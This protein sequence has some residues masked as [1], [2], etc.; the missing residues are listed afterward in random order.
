MGTLY[1]GDNLDILRRYL[2]DESVDLVYLDPPFNSAQTYNAFFHEKDGTEAASQIK[3]FEDTWHWDIQ[4]MA[5]YKQITEQPGKVSDVMQAFYTFLG[6][7]DMMAYLTMMAPRLVELRRVL[8][9]TG[10]LYLHCDPTASHYLKLLCD[11]VFG[12]L[13]YRNEISWRRSQP[14]SHATV[15]FPNCRDVILRYSKGPE[16]IFNKVFGQHDP[17]YIQ[18]FYR[19]ADPNGRKY[20]LG[21]ITNPNKNRPNLTYE[22]L[23]VTRVWR[24]TKD[25]MQRA[26]EEGRIYQSKPGAVPQEKRYLDDMEGQPISD[27]WHDIEHLHGSNQEKLPYP[28]QK[29]VALLE[30]IIKASSNP[31][32]VVLDP[33]CGCGTT[34]DAAEKLGRQWIGI[35]IT[36]LAISLI[37]NRLQDTYG[38]RMKFVTGSAHTAADEESFPLPQGEG[39]TPGHAS[40]QAAAVSVVRIVGE[41]TT[42]NEAA[43]LA[44]QDKFQFQWWALGLVGARPVEQKKGADHGI[45]GKILFRDDPQ[46]AKPEQIIIQVKGGKTGVK[47]VRDLRGVID[48][49]KAA[50]GVLISLQPPTGPMEAEAASV[51]FYEHKLTRQKYPRLQLRTVKELMEGKGI[52]R[53]SEAA[54]VD[55]TF[56]KAPESKKKHGQQGDLAL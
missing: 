55:M 23:G 39:A 33:F 36:Q 27:D 22:F 21:D 2:K 25:R 16:V 50:I 10:S 48:R 29:P 45:D 15:N 30:R 17:E 47:D 52:E 34:I 8:K 51:G 41:P 14:K 7:N 19:F 35:D 37:K 44:E 24:W 18:K 54:A 38:S 6:G 4:T 26:Y 12:P 56:K 1:Y 3:A 53:P 40:S 32:D 11:A 43:T 5:A 13:N 31:G 42:P 46:A 9:P 20:R 28:T 49:E